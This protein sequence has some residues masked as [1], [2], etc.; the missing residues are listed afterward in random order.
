MF[1]SHSRPSF[2]RK[3]PSFLCTNRGFLNKLAGLLTFNA[4]P[5]EKEA[6]NCPG[7]FHTFAV[8]YRTVGAAPAIHFPLCVR[9]MKEAF[10]LQSRFRCWPLFCSPQP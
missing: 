2:Y 5:R 9:G 8:R 3:K 1:A 10:F 6:L 7:G 4:V